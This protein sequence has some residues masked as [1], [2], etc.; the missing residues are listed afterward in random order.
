MTTQPAAQSTQIEASDAEK[1]KLD[2]FASKIIDD[3]AVLS[4]EGDT[5]SGNSVVQGHVRHF[6]GAARE[7]DLNDAEITR[8][9]LDIFT[10]QH[11]GRIPAVMVGSNGSMD[12]D[13]F[14]FGDAA[15]NRET[16]DAA[17]YVDSLRLNESGAS[18]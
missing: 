10:T 14:L 7:A 1:R 16:D 15:V 11:S 8:Y 9:F 3:L 6:V 13:N 5:D 4:T 2:Y 17:D 12:I 18:N